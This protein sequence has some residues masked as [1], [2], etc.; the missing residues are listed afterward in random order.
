MFSVLIP[1]AW[2]FILGQEGTK[3]YCNGLHLKMM[4]S[5]TGCYGGCRFETA[6]HLNNSQTCWIVS[7]ASCK[8]AN[9]WLLIHNSHVFV[10]TGIIHICNFV[11]KVKKKPLT[12][13]KWTE[14]VWVN[15]DYLFLILFKYFIPPTVLKC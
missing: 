13:H 11:V 14:K 2:C 9:L 1:N 5:W 3:L 4:S 10:L 12:V 15:R 6:P 8:S 7:V